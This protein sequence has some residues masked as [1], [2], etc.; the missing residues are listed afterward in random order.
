MTKKNNNYLVQGSVL[1]IAGL[2]SRVIGL[3]YKIPLT[4]IIGDEGMSYYS[5]AYEIYNLALLVS[6]YSIPVAISKLISAKDR[7]KEYKNSNRI[8]KVAFL[9]SGLLGLIITVLIFTFAG[10]I[11]ELWDTPSMK[12]PLKAMAPTLL[13]F[14]LMSVIRGFFQGKRRMTPTAVSQII[15]QVFHALGSILAAYLLIRSAGENAKLRA[16]YGATGGTLGTLIGAVFG[17]IFL[18]LVFMMNMPYIKEK[19]NRDLT[20][21]EDKYSDIAWS[22]ITTMLPIVLSQTVYQ[23]SGTIDDK[24]FK[25]IMVKKGYD[26]TSRAILWEAFSNKYKTL[27][28]VPVAIASA[29]GVSVVPV[30]SN[31]NKA[32][33]KD[34][35]YSTIASHIKLN[36]I[37][38][39]PSAVGLSVLAKPILK[40]LYNISDSSVAPD[41]LI[42]GGIAVIF[43]AL[44]TFTNG[45]LQGIDR[46]NLPVIHSAISLA[47]HIP[48]LYLLIDVLE[49]GPYG[50]VI[51]NVTYALLVSL[52]NGFSIAKITGYKQEVQT[53]FIVPAISSLIMG[54]VAWLIYKLLQITLKINPISCII[55]ISVAAVVYFIAL[56][57]LKGLTRE[58]LAGIPKGH[59]LVKAADKLH[60]L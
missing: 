29:L 26:E 6:T 48:L 19:G 44:S 54:V 59:I 12:I 47:V 27:I 55:S 7:S 40:M 58:E 5:S 15:E 39:M 24:I 32:K 50:L 51:G 9:I 22:I 35:I 30:L 16:V 57:K 13:V 4:R 36:M 28:N 56:I 49:L 52:L 34:G 3:I 20:G 60:L 8:V 53:T 25:S 18:F 38:A 2:L 33:D 10:Q 14:S 46:L 43:F 1:A 23:L 37:V 17:L 21:R 42:L 41:L 45:V 31:L 11:A